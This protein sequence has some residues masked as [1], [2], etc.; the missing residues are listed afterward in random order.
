[1]SQQ[2]SPT[3]TLAHELA[4]G[5]GGRNLLKLNYHADIEFCS[6]INAVP[7]LPAF[8]SNTGEIGLIAGAATA[9]G[10]AE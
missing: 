5:A 4:R 6:Q 7:Q 10:V 1:V 2:L 9:D 3:V 8:H